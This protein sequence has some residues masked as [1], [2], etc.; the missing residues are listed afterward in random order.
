M[1]VFTESIG[2]VGRANA[3]VDVS[4]E[5][6]ADAD[7]DTTG[8]GLTLTDGVECSA[9]GHSGVTS[10][11]SLLASNDS[12][13]SSGVT[14]WRTTSGIV[15][16]YREIDGGPTDRPEAILEECSRRSLAFAASECVLAAAT[17][18]SN[19]ATF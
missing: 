15:W 9:R 6:I 7:L 13:G 1:P 19:W 3:S 18:N 14:S 5:R 12:G 17:A 16:K 2:G 4:K 11:K 8:A 10:A